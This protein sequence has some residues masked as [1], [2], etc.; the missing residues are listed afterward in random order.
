MVGSRTRQASALILA[1]ATLLAVLLTSVNSATANPSIRSK[2]AEAQAVL[3]QIQQS[4]IQLEKA[5]E[6]YNLANVQLGKID[7]DLKTNAYHLKVAKKSLKTAQANVA[8]RLRALYV[9]GDGGGAIEVILGAQ[10]LDDLL[11]RLDMVQRVGNQDS[12]VLRAVKVFRTEVKSRGEKLKKARA[13]Q[14]QV[15]AQRADQKRSIESQ[16]AERQRLLSGIQGEIRQLQAAEARRQA[17]LRAQAQARLLAQQ[18]AQEAAAQAQVSTL[19]TTDFAAAAASGDAAAADPA[20]TPPPPSQYSG[21]VGI[22]MQEL[23]KPYVWGAAGPSSFDCSGLVMYA[24]AQM[25]ISLPHNAAAQYGY[26]SPVAYND[27]QPGDLVFFDGLGHV[28]IY[29]GGGQF[30]HAPHTGDVVKISSL[31]EHGGFVGARRI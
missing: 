10:S 22:A 6:S 23:G 3:A 19:S 8:A 18:R 28:G 15:V 31:S 2:Q 4:D 13:A 24:F 17:E 21:V 14:A 29:I 11:A 16:L 7:G 12:R 1:A 26:G 20:P 9:N 27:L 5:I 25:G 30:I